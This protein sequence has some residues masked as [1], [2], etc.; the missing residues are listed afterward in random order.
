MADTSQQTYEL[1]LSDGAILRIDSKEV[2]RDGERLP[3][4]RMLHCTLYCL[5]KAHD[6]GIK[7]PEIKK[8]C[9]TTRRPSQ[10]ISDLKKELKDL[11]LDLDKAIR[12]D[13]SRYR[14]DESCTCKP[15]PG[16]ACDTKDDVL[17]VLTPS[18]LAPSTR[19][20]AVEDSE[21]NVL[22][23]KLGSGV[24]R[25]EAGRG[26]ALEATARRA[27]PSHVPI[28]SPPSDEALDPAPLAPVAS[29]V[30]EQCEADL[31]KAVATMATTMHRAAQLSLLSTLWGGEG[32][33]CAAVSVGY[34]MMVGLAL[35]VEVA[36]QW[37]EFSGWAGPAAAVAGSASAIVAAA[38]FGLMRWRAS[39]GRFD[40]VGAS[41][42]IFSVWSILVAMSLAGRL[43]ER[44][45]VQAYFQTM[46]AQVGWSKSVLEALALPILSLVPLQMVFAMRYHLSS[47]RSENVRQVLTERSYAALPVPFVPSPLAAS[48]VFAV[49]TIWWLRANAHLLENLKVGDFYGLFLALA[50]LR[51][52][53]GLIPLCVVLCWYLQRWNAFKLPV[54]E[55]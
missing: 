23:R 7:P 33:I 4:R 15:V 49:V 20:E 28:P 53:A 9:D 48:V 21:V 30:S 27:L 2:Y 6:L 10:T 24:I 14:F 26:Y 54:V 44:P 45:I 19:P 17:S 51:V 43:P 50:V 37:P 13:G 5:A 32:P 31:P 25:T 40:S 29:T 11:D 8:A 52:S 41:A 35:L 46:T 12:R 18:P 1:T 47:G 55:S 3:L 42:T 36:Y 16:R 39:A 38:T 34:G 22:R